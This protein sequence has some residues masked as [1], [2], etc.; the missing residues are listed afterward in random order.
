MCFEKTSLIDELY[1]GTSLEN[2][3][4]LE[5]IVFIVIITISISIKMNLYFFSYLPVCLANRLSNWT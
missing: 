1:V 3:N 5:I 2:V 4:L